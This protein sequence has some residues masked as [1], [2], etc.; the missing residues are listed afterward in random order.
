MANLADGKLQRR[1]KVFPSDPAWGA[2][3]DRPL[4]AGGK[5]GTPLA[6]S[7][8]RPAISLRGDPYESQL[9]G[10]IHRRALA[11]RGRVRGGR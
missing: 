10:A 9:V 4:A 5:A 6:T 3:L 11:V 2:S 8:V 7:C 1:R